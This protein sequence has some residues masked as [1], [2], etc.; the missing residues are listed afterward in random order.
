MKILDIREELSVTEE[1][2]N[3]LGLDRGRRQILI[4]FFLDYKDVK[5][6]FYSL[7]SLQIWTLSRIVELIESATERIIRNRLDSGNKAA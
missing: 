1:E 5:E 2:I 6:I 7:M 4:R 3:N